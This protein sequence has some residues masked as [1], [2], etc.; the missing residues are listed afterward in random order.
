MKG[1]KALS[2]LHHAIKVGGNDF[3]TYVTGYNVAD[4][5]IMFQNT[6]F[7]FDAFFCHQRGIGCDAIEHPEVLR[8]FY[9]FKVGSINK[10]FHVGIDCLNDV[11]CTCESTKGNHN[12]KKK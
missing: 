2:F 6:G 4:V 11:D 9:L 12:W 8:F 3:G 1:S 5:N 7:A 10:E